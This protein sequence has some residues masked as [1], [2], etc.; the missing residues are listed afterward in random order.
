[1]VDD[2]I[3]RLAEL[4]DG[5][6]DWYYDCILGERGQPLGNLAN[7][8]T[9]LRADPAWQGKF[10]FDLMLMAAMWMRERPITDSDVAGVQEWLQHAGMRSVGKDTV[11]QAV[12]CVAR[13][14]AY[15]PVRSYLED[16]TWDGIPR[17]ADWLVSYLGA[18][19]TPYVTG[20][21]TVF[22]ISMVAR[23]LRPGCKVDH[24]L[25]LEGPQ[26][27]L[28][29]TAC[30]V[31]GDKWFSDNLPEI[32]AGKDVSQHLRGKWLIEVSEMHAMSRAETSLHKS[33]I[34]RDTE[35]YRPSSA[36]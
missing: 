14:H 28:K 4:Q 21:G 10:N 5:T 30:R 35:R 31:L 29:S 36:G 1:M 26:G 24:M 19:Q 25:I 33:F 27:I 6:P 23:I 13:E 34:T 16:L 18:E 9:A 20:V 17:L 15:H 8:L 11:F 7:V 2:N 3:I 12:D 32:T 22:M